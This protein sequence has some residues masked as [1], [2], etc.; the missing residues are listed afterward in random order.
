MTI[1]KNQV[2]HVAAVGREGEI[3]LRW[4][5]SCVNEFD[6]AFKEKHVFFVVDTVGTRF[7]CGL[8]RF[9]IDQSVLP[10]GKFS[11]G[12]RDALFPVPNGDERNED[13]QRYEKNGKEDS[14]N[15]GV[16]DGYEDE[17]DAQNKNNEQREDVLY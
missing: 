12:Q 17:Y 11:A 7:P 2:E 5:D 8:M 15:A 6:A 1:Q 13:H 16:S 10:N 9:Y 4:R 3:L 14:L